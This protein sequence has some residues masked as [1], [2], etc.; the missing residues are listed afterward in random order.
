MLVAA[1]VKASWGA[2]KATSTSQSRSLSTM[3][4]LVA[5]WTS[6]KTS[7]MVMDVIAVKGI[8]RVEA[9]VV[10]EEASGSTS[11]QSQSTTTGSEL[12]SL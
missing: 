8:A 2:G 1:G 3:G 6:G 5:G 10:E 12:G 9:D 11:T 4:L 7:Q